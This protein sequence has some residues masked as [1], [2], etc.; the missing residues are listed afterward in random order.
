MKKA[1]I[2][3][4]A[5]QDG[6][7]LAELLVGK[8]YDVFGLV[9]QRMDRSYVPAAVH[10]LFGDLTDSE[11]LKVAVQAAVPDEVYNLAGVTDLKTAYAK[12]EMTWKINYES[13]GVLLDASLKINPHVRFFQ[14]SSAEIF[15]PSPFPLN[16]ES[17]RDWDT[18]NPYAIAKMSADRDF[19]VGSREKRE[20]FACS[21]FLFNHE[22]P[23]RS[24]AFVTRKITRTLAKVELGLASCLSIGNIEMSR[25]WGFAG[26]Y[27][28]AMWKMLQL[29][30]PQDFVIATG[31]LHTVRDAINIAAQTLGL[32]LVW[33]G[34]GMQTYAVD[35]AGKKIV[36]VEPE[37]YRPIATSP[38]VG[39]IC[40]AEK[41][42]DWKPTV[43]FRALVEMMIKSDLAELP[44]DVDASA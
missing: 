23:R 2:T 44:P 18:K 34:E 43:D 8:G 40:K 11:S 17:S 16:E 39:N 38:K 28:A 15:L 20:A 31:K 37:L 13:V 24:A 1:L 27:V 7:Y 12:P 42:M 10:T 4:V 22:S 35:S 29:D 26:D 19:I 25:D 14:A 30:T 6:S 32:E 5:G 3:G 36:E 21:A 9:Q 41:I 33:H